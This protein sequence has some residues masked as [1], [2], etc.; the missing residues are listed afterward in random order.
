M[1]FLKCK[2]CK[3]DVIV[4]GEV[5]LIEPKIKCKKCGFT[6]GKKDIKNEPVVIIKKKK[7]NGR[8][9]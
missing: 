9:K 2:I 3:G 5:S 7:N 6:N 8:L 4:C 1:S